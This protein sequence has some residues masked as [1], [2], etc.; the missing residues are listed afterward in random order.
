MEKAINHFIFYMAM[1]AIILMIPRIIENGGANI[2]DVI[3]LTSDGF[4]VGDNI[5]HIVR[6]WP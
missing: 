4:L 5:R 6:W 1:L 2:I 3:C